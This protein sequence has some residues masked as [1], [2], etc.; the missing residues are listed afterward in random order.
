MTDTPN[1]VKFP[2]GR[3]AFL[4]IHGIGEQNPFETLDYFAQNFVKYFDEQNVNIQLEH[5]IARRR[6][7]SGSFWTESFIRLSPS[8]TEQDWFIDIH[9]YYWAPDTENQISA[10]EVLRWAEQTLDG[11]IKF[12]SRKDN[13]H[14]VD[15]LLRRRDSQNMFKFRLRSLT[16]FLRI[17]NFFYPILRLLI[18]VILLLLGPF[19]KGSFLGSAWQ[20]SKV[21]ITPPLVNFVGDIAIYTKTNPKSPYQ[22]I[23][24]RVLAESLAL[25]KGILKDKQADYQQ[26]ILAGHSLGSCIAYDT[27]NL[28]CIEAS[29]T[30]DQSKIMFVN[31][32]QG[33]ITFGSPLDKIAFFFREATQENQYIRQRILEHL[34]SFR[35]KPPIKPEI[36][37][38]FVKQS[39]YF[40]NSPV[41]CRL[42]QV[43]WVNYYHLKDPI[44][45][46][47]DYYDNLD[48]VELKYDASWGEQ[49]HLGYWTDVK[50]YEHI[51]NNFLSK[52][53]DCK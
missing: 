37:T 21:L 38:E 9:E 7:S 11:T 52:V 28:L 40:S 42:N 26:V 6:L 48:N 49:G 36:K 43:R 16:I 33:L 15:D 17:F 19:F 13:Q 39:K 50:F 20:L 4:L 3:T 53:P 14:L 35:V 47:L 25:L 24:Q 31:K 51:A 1:R 12:Y 18:W 8:D 41:V 5:L 10:P 30:K 44:S 27:L 32:L 29:L 23:R 2:Q 22:K 46:N 34:K 45:G